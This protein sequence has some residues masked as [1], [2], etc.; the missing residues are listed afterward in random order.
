MIP[1][2]ILGIIQSSVM[3]MSMFQIQEKLLSYLILALEKSVPWFCKSFKL[4]FYTSYTFKYRPAKSPEA[5]HGCIFSVGVIKITMYLC[6][7]EEY[8]C[9]EQQRECDDFSPL[10]IA[11]RFD[12][13]LF[14]F[15]VSFRGGGK[16][17]YGIYFLTHKY[18]GH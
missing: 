15:I 14:H 9:T 16:Y 17:G 4:L 13:R 18:E 7:R 10:D 11:S 6:V 5:F 2:E 12:V 3:A 1:N 8:G